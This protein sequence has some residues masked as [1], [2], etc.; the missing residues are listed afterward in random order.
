MFAVLELRLK[1]PDQKRIWRVVI[2]IGLLGLLLGSTLG[3]VWHHHANPSS[4][5]CL[6]C[7]LVIAPSVA[8]IRHPN[9]PVTRPVPR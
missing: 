4:D 9:I 7:H 2:P 6:L 1:M 3:V 5:N 8:G